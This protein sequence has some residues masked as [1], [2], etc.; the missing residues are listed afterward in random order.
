LQGTRHDL[1]LYVDSGRLRR[2]LDWLPFALAE[3]KSQ[4]GEQF[5][6]ERVAASVKEQAVR[7]TK[8]FLRE[9]PGLQDGASQWL[10]QFRRGRLVMELNTDTLADS[11]NHFSQ[12][13]RRVTVALILIGMLIGSAIA[14]SQ[15]PTLQQTEWALVPAVAM[16]IFVG[17]AL[18][19]VVVV[20]QMLQEER[21]GKR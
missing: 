5:T 8:D 9:L 18:L 17:S 14:A 3:A 19:S 12:S 1:E 13:M 15:W 10:E 11:V 6:V 16:G 21:G 2:K 20:M 7:S 4:L